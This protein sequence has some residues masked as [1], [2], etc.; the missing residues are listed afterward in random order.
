MEY[1]NGIS[2]KQGID[3]YNIVDENERYEA[4]DQWKGVT[5]TNLP[6]PVFNFL[7]ESRKFMTSQIQDNELT[8]KYQTLYI[9]YDNAE[10]SSAVSAVCNQ[11]TDYAKATWERLGMEYENIEGLRDAFVSGDYILYHWWNNEIETGQPFKGD[12]DCMRIDN[13]NYYPANPNSNKVQSQPYIILAMRDMVKNVKSEAQKNG[14]SKN[15]LEQITQDEDTEYTAGDMGKYELDGGEKCNVL[16]KMWKD[17]GKVW[18]AK[19]TKYVEIQKPK[20]SKLTLY[21]ISIMN[22][23]TRKN[24]CHGTAEITYMKT[25]QTYINKQMAF[26]QLYLLQTAYPKV[27]YD[28]TRITEG[29]SNKVAGAIGVNGEVEY[30]AKYM[31]P[32]Q[33]PFDVWTGFEKTLNV[34]KQLMGANDAALGNIDNPDNTSAFIAIRNAA[35]AP[36]QTQKKRFYRMMKD[37]AMIWLDF[38]LSHYSENRRIP[39][40]ANGQ[41]TFVNFELN[42]FKDLI[43]DC[44]IEVGRSKEWS[45]IDDV[46]TLGNFLQTKAIPAS[47]YF[48]VLPK[49]YMPEESREEAI[50]YAQQIEQMQQPTEQELPFT[51]FEGLQMEQLE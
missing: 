43:Y 18:F 37:T 21:P 44:Q 31:Q 32:P 28:K 8:M 50:A 27:V 42:K 49:G 17:K 3:L 38:W 19:Y 36:L 12:I 5:A 1:E 11:M 48:K 20:E 25:N 23:E 24:C 40:V 29:W 15:L 2:F 47:L 51:D 35:V 26:T 41:T 4:G 34:T 22:W 45:E 33:I 30:V 13:V 39:V 14:I 10:M 7:K 16:L 6:T 46:K 9:P